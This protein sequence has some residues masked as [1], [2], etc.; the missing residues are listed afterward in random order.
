MNSQRI[1]EIDNTAFRHNWVLEKLSSLAKQ[2]S[3]QKILDVGA[4]LS[5]Y[6]SHAIDLGFQYYSQDFSAY[7]PTGAEQGLHDKN[8]HYP[9]HT[10][11]CDILEIPKTQKY[12]L[13]LCTEVFEHIPDPIRSFAYLCRLLKNNGTIVITVPFMSLMHQ[14]PYWFQ[15]GLS[16]FWFEY[17]SKTNNLE[18][19]ELKVYGDYI[20]LVSQE[21]KRLLSFSHR[22]SPISKVAIPIIKRLR[23]RHSKAVLDSGGFGTLFVARRITQTNA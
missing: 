7:T 1:V 16:P 19:L 10:F 3:R 11:V 20:D 9:K 17:W 8:W 5:P 14:A 4:G 15:S 21:T 6:K 18:I 2:N 13:I 12:D 22:A 23:K